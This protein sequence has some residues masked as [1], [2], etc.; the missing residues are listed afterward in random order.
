MHPHCLVVAAVLAAGSA[1]AAQTPMPQASAIADARTD[2]AATVN[3]EPI[4]VSE[5]DAVLQASLRAVPLTTA[6][7][8]ELRAALLNDLIDEKLLRQFL[9]K[10][11]PR[12]DPAE[13][14]AQMT[15][16]KASLIHEN[17]TLADFLK[18]SGQTEAQLR[19]EW[20]ARIQMTNYVKGLASSRLPRRSSRPLRPGRGPRQS[21]RPSPGQERASRGARRRE[22]KA[23]GHPRRYP[24]RPHH[25]HRGCKEVVPVS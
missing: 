22:G 10:N 11:A 23:R 19:D 13:L 16:L 20:T 15:A 6:Q 17:R 7:R 24:R 9:A 25:L 12:V 18:Q 4:A 3:G 21:H 2:V 1:L 8:R 14:D 5:L